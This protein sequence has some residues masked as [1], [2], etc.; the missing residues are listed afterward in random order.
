MKK[1]LPM[2]RTR[3]TLR[4]PHGVYSVRDVALLFG[5][6]KAGRAYHADGELVWRLEICECIRAINRYLRD[7]RINL[8]WT[9]MKEYGYELGR[10][11]PKREI[12]KY[13]R[14]AKNSRLL[15]AEAY[16]AMSETKGIP[17]KVRKA[18]KKLTNS[19]NASLENDKVEFERHLRFLF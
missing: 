15:E 1:N 8:R 13:N 11:D 19:R 17:M 3:K 16:L 5:I 2:E 6:S 7:K 10:I 12:V 9:K 18:L 14:L 4:M